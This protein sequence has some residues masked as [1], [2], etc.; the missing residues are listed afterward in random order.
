MPLHGESYRTYNAYIP[1]VKKDLDGSVALG[2]LNWFE[3]ESEWPDTYFVYSN[4]NEMVRLHSY[5]IS[6]H[7]KIQS[8]PWTV[9]KIFLGFH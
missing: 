2:F 9:P 8:N 4:K 5:F 3:I 7:K 6:F 1:T